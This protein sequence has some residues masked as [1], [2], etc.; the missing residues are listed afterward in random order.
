MPTV[1]QVNLEWNFKTSQGLNQIKYPLFRYNLGRLSKT[2]PIMPR[3]FI[4]EISRK[5]LLFLGLTMWV[6]W[7]ADHDIDVSQSERLLLSYQLS[8]PSLPVTQYTQT[9][10]WTL[11]SQPHLSNIRLYPYYVS[12]L[13]VVSEAW[14]CQGAKEHLLAVSPGVPCSCCHND[15]VTGL[16][17]SRESCLIAS[18]APC[19]QHMQCL[20]T[21]VSTR[22][23]GLPGSNIVSGGS[24]AAEASLCQ[25]CPVS[26]CQVVGWS[27]ARVREE[28]VPAG[29]EWAGQWAVGWP[30]RLVP[31]SPTPALALAPTQ[32]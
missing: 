19:P 22:C 3:V 26:S 1:Y 18:L 31:Q 8:F 21:V 16:H 29:S 28:R 25:E 32:R 27:R 13:S 30:V 24:R 10:D 5:F 2:M 6:T 23:G 15:N 12:H 9:T 17:V 4:N 7:D 11:Y 20:S 14:P